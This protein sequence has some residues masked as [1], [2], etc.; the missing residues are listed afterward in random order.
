[1]PSQPRVTGLVT[2]KQAVVPD[3]TV[4]GLSIWINLGL[5]IRWLLRVVSVNLAFLGR[6]SAMSEK[7]IAYVEV[8]KIA[9]LH[10]LVG[11]MVIRWLAERSRPDYVKREKRPLVYCPLASL[12]RV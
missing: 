8:P 6:N 3:R 10:A 1:M 4:A 5:E 12:L 11:L 7:A 9:R 2:V